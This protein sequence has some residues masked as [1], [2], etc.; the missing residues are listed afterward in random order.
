L[1]AFFRDLYVLEFREWPSTHGI[2]C[3]I[4]NCPLFVTRQLFYEIEFDTWS[5]RQH[6][7]ETELLL[8]LK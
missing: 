5:T 6:G 3:Q 1:E 2:V 7:E 8:V 4:F